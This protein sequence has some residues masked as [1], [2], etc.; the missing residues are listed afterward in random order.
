MKNY[1]IDTNVLIQA[2]NALWAFQE[3]RIVIP[4]VVVEELDHLKKAEGEKGANA[5]K[6]IRCLE[7][8]RHQGDLLKGVRIGQEGILRIEKNFVYVELPEE[9]PD[10]RA[11]NRILQ[12]CVGMREKEKDPVI[13]V[14]KDLLLRLKAQLLGIQAEDFE[15]EQVE[16]QKLQYTG[17][18]EV[19]VPEEYFKDFKKKGIPVAVVYKADEQGEKVYPELTENQFLILRSDQS[20]KKSQLG[21]VEGEMIRKLAYRKAEPYGIHPR[22]AGQY[23]FQEALMQSAEKAPLVIVKGMAGTSKT[24]PLMRPIMDNLEQLIDSNEE[25]RYKDEN[26]L[27]GKIEEIFGRELIQA[28]A[29][30][31]IRGRSLIQT[32]L[33]IDEA[34]NTTPNQI[35]GIITRA[36]KN[37]KIILLGDPN[38]IDRPFLDERT[39]GLSYAAEHMKGSSLCWQITMSPEECERSELAMDAIQRLEKRTEKKEYR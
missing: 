32:Y 15:A 4:L 36:G 17:R 10:D 12:V 1:V 9:L 24:S 34:Q 18:D 13:L 7:Q 29:L 31:F 26:E 16:E 25:E 14:T 8:L 23:F 11:D 27:K 35:K 20:E 19:F 3:N 37:T 6:V 39:N 28:E 38:Q 30:N 22:N 2:P 33:I 21:R 5:R